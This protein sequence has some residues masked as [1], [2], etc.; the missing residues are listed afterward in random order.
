MAAILVLMITDPLLRIF[1]TENVNFAC[2][3]VEEMEKME[4]PGDKYDKAMMA[5]KVM[6]HAATPEEKFVDDFFWFIT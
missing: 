5:V 4:M 2:L 3:R 6:M 1:G